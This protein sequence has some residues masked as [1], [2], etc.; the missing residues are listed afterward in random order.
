MSESLPGGFVLLP[1]P[2]RLVEYQQLRA[3]T[4]LPLRTDAQAVGALRGSWAFCT[5]R[6]PAGALVAMGRVIGDGGWSF[7][8]AELVTSPPY[9]HRGLGDRV[10][11][12][13]LTQ[14][15]DRAPAGASLTA[16]ATHPAAGC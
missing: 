3:D 4:G 12:W 5:V 8:L 11:A 15:R 1:V 10:L 2:P 9:Q 7:T 16:L 13:L 6:A 14:I